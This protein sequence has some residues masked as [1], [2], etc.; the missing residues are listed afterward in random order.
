MKILRLDLVAFGPFTE[1]ILDLS[2]GQQGFH[3]IYGPNEA[4]KSTTL[5]ALR[6]LLFGIPANSTDNFVHA[7]PALRIGAVLEGR[8]G[9]R[10]ECVRRKG[11]KNTLLHPDETP[12][13]ESNL[14]VL[15]GGVDPKLFEAMFGIDHATLVRGG[16]AILQGGGEIGQILFAAGASIAGLRTVQKSLEDEA[17][18][19][20]LPQGKNPR[21]NQTLSE[22]EKVRWQMR[23]SQLPGT[24]WA[25]HDE[26]LTD[27]RR[28][29]Q[30]VDAELDSLLGEK[31]RLERTRD[32]LPAIAARATRLR[33]REPFA[34]AMLLP[35]NF[36]TQRHEA[37]H[38]RSQSQEAEREAAQALSDLEK[39]IQ[40][41]DAAVNEAMLA[42]AAAV[43]QM[44]ERLG[45]H[46]KA[47]TDR[48][49]L[50]TEL[51]GIEN[52]ARTI[53]R[54]LRPEFDLD[55]AESLRLSTPERLRI[56]ELAPQRQGL[57]QAVDSTDAYVKKIADAVESANRRLT[58]MEAERDAAALRRALR[59]LEQAG[60]VQAQCED[61]RATV[62][63]DEEQ[64]D[65]D[66]RALPLFAGSM[67]ELERLP[68]PS[69]DVIEHREVEYAEC[70]T[71]LKELRA[72]IDDLRAEDADLAQ[73]IAQLE[74]EQAV[75]S[76]VE[77]EAC[78]AQRDSEWKQLRDLL[79]TP[80][81]TPSPGASLRAP[82]VPPLAD[83]FEQNLRRTDDVADRLR[84]EAHRVAQRAQ[85]AAERVT[86]AERLAQL[87]SPLMEAESRCQAADQSWVAL[88]EPT[89]ILP[90]SPREMRSWARQWS[91][92]AATSRSLRE[93]RA[94]LANLEEGVR[95]HRD[96]LATA[97]R[98]LGE[99]CTDADDLPA[100]VERGQRMLAHLDS[101]TQLRNQLRQE[102]ALRTPELPQAETAARQAQADF[103]AWRQRWAEA[104]ARLGLGSEPTPG[105]AAAVLDSL[106]DLFNRLEAARK[107]RERI[108]GIEHDAAEFTRDLRAFVERVAPDVGG[109]EPEPAVVELGARLARARAAC[110][111]RDSLVALRERETRKRQSA[112]AAVAEAEGR[113]DI[114]R[115][116]AGCASIDD[117]GA[118]E[119]RSAERRRLD[120]EIRRLEEQILQ[121]SGG[122]SLDSFIAEAQS[123]EPDALAGRIKQLEH[124]VAER[125]KEKENL[126]QT[127]GAETTLLQQMDGSAR[128]AE[129]AEQVQGLLAQ[130]GADAEQ[131]A[132]LKLAT[133]VL[134]IGIER[135]RERNQG[136]VLRRAGELFATLTRGSFA[137]LRV[138]FNDKGEAV[139]FGVRPGG[140]T[141]VGV[142]GMSTGSRDQLYLALRLAS[143]ETYLERHEPLPFIVDDVL[144][145][146]DDD[147]ARAVLRVLAEFSKRTQVIFFT[148]HEH[149]VRL[150]EGTL[151]V[152]ALFVHRLGVN[153]APVPVEAGTPATSGWLFQ[154]DE[155]R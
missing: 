68:V 102:L 54:G 1:T 139:L 123:A 38:Q 57:A 151:P 41:L 63:R 152:N 88:W 116:D 73:K 147:R 7:Y 39:E 115:R 43:Q 111:K 140:K 122:A 110:E 145:H 35:E 65:I 149:L 62:R 119:Q 146:F 49:R 112:R 30:A 130:A 124:H 107:H 79:T 69:A 150:A 59:R 133:H 136:P 55:A 81:D 101:L 118:A 127:I 20:F 74:M 106:G 36:G 13:E 98:D 22:L 64:A 94:R 10:L 29:K 5:R 86:G 138:D 142:D 50:E 51:R 128:S 42:Q 58:D 126:D 80:S 34:D 85:L 109:F 89:G 70:H 26:A 17:N 48:A 114:L 72:R 53:L 24:E 2:A 117:L 87:Q 155:S 11:N 100:L 21:L 121:R 12:L 27:A 134:R 45:S 76:E 97:L 132:R 141:T 61:L 37:L 105:Q 125:Q 28:R 84:R 18:A 95:G 131:Y 66:R 135:Y 19:L 92:Q 82:G 56:Q 93:Q 104:T 3:V 78:R 108:G 47:G 129:A 103:D 9:T 31:S 15:L 44:H 25:K 40:A 153:E 32:A 90:L 14:D 96:D 75:P 99:A 120:A 144:I 67:E 33:E 52:D 6:H 113:L 71:A 23:D 77:L 91:E 60:P 46:K 137:G 154:A 16:E 143:L 8:D 83:S 4:G 148:H